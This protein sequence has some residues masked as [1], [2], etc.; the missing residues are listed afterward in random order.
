MIW[1]IGLGSNIGDRLT[2]LQGA[3]DALREAGVTVRGVSAVYETAPVGGPE[4][5]PYLNA[6]VRVETDLAPHHLL[7]LAQRIEAHAGRVRS[8]RWG[9]RPL[10]VDLLRGGDLA[11]DDPDLMLPHP[12]MWERAFVLVPL[13]DLDPQVDLAAVDTRGVRRT[14]LRLT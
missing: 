5:G 4:Q 7:D 2:H 10:D 9:P 14:G 1:D 11:L 8:V 13:A 12:R 3:V 6:V